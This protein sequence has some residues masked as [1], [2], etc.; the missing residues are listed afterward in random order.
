[1]AVFHRIMGEL[2]VNFLKILC[3]KEVYIL[4]K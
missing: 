1:M 2:I 4:L 3:F